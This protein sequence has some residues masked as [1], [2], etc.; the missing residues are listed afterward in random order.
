[1]D[2]ILWMWTST[3]LLVGS[4]EKHSLKEKLVEYL[5]RHSP[6]GQIQDLL[7]EV[8]LS[9]YKMEQIQKASVVFIMI[10]YMPDTETE[11]KR[12]WQFNI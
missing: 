4:S 7:V 5:G 6:H 10:S 1:M 12:K 9:M 8:S 2:A 3:N 11:G